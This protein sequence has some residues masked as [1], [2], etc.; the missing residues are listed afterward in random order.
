ML[1]K[2]RL[3]ISNI[4]VLVIPLIIFAA[5]TFCTVIIIKNNI[6]NAYHIKFGMNPFIDFANNGVQVMNEIEQ[7]IESDPSYLNNVNYYNY[8]DK[9][10]N[11]NTGI[12]IREDNSIKYESA[13]LK[14]IDI[15]KELPSFGS[16]LRSFSSHAFVGNMNVLIRQYDF[17]FENGNKGSIFIVTDTTY[18]IKMIKVFIM[19]EAIAFVLILIV[20][21][22]I[23][24][25]IV[26][27]SIITP[28]EALKN[29]ANEIKEGNLDFELINNNGDEVSEVSK[30][31]EEMRLKLKDSMQKQIQ[32]ETNR[33]ELISNISHDLK[34]PVTAIKGYVEG[35]K[36]GI[37][38]T[39]EKMEKYIQTIYL[40]ANDMD[41]LIEELFLFSK[42][43]LNSVPFHFEKVDIVSYLK[44][45]IEEFQ[46]DLEK[47]SIE[48]DLK[49]EG[50]T[51]IYVIADREK[52]RRVLVNIVE[53]S[54]KYIDKD[55]G[56]INI[57]LREKN[58]FVE[59]EIKDNG[60]GIL[61]ESIPH[62]FDRFYRGDLAR[63]SNTGGSGLGLSIAKKII[64]E[65]GGQIKAKSE[66]YKGTSITFTLKK[67]L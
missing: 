46:F 13:F 16:F 58:N 41:K 44:Y 37:A 29:G 55:K 65:H 2:T 7:D 38:D 5:F 56:K 10:L 11:D 52:I 25:F 57:I 32:Y 28:L 63:N 62:I 30:A 17:Y 14:K 19:T 21:N 39:P 12:V 54:I 26:S 50:R 66:E 18:L 60:K 15:K 22:I 42:L 33:K 45:N 1:I 43:D 64:E 40:K 9:K 24:T 59:I 20:T 49:V 35:I 6:E 4:A 47:R 67:I 27:K 36:D 8:I 31:F 3:R 48:I 51:K 61:K 34:T 23:L 53:N